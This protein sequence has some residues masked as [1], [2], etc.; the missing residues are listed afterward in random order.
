MA[1]KNTQLEKVQPKN[2]SRF[3]KLKNISVIF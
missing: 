2:K 1:P 3:Q